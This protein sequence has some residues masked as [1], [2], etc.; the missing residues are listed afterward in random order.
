MIIGDLQRF[1]FG[2]G[3]GFDT[4]D[5]FCDCGLFMYTHTL[6]DS[7]CIRSEGT[8]GIG[9]QKFIVAWTIK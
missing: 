2:T 7:A 1:C 4:L 6:N 5:Y 9:A 8:L 3:N